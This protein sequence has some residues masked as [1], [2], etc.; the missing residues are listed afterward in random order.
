[1]DSPT[2]NHYPA[3]RFNL[4]LSGS[5]HNASFNDENDLH[6][7][8]F[9]S[10]IDHSFQ[11]ERR[12]SLE[13]QT[14]QLSNSL[15]STNQSLNE[16][17]NRNQAKP[18][19]IFKQ[20][21]RRLSPA[22][23]HLTDANNNNNSSN[24]N[25]NIIRDKQSRH[26]IGA[27]NQLVMPPSNNLRTNSLSLDLNGNAL[28][29]RKSISNQYSPDNAFDSWQKN[30]N[31][32]QYDSVFESPQSSASDQIFNDQNSKLESSFISL[33]ISWN[34]SNAEDTSLNHR[35]RKP[36]NSTFVSNCVS[37]NISNGVSNPA[38]TSN[39]SS[40]TTS[41]TESLSCLES[42]F[43]CLASDLNEFLK[44]LGLD[45]LKSLFEEKNVDLH[46]FLTLSEVDLKQFGIT[47]LE[48]LATL[49][50]GQLKFKEI[51]SIGSSESMSYVIYLGTQLER[52]KKELAKV[53]EENRLYKMGLTDIKGFNEVKENKMQ[54]GY[55]R[56]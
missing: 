45:E 52:T 14:S 16:I 35:E 50:A 15:L 11:N 27:A 56:F 1:M 28:T 47:N 7:S 17:L 30:Q 55:S 6:Q 53:K 25:S 29:N 19:P 42:K 36:R 43:A 13:T 26:S 44:Q 23:H 38:S 22:S 8:S 5:N 49:I 33:N 10:S 32:F 41:P 4:I 51:I 31:L 3:D 46:T 9:N 54:N 12:F 40:Q 2:S 20:R 37:N 39:S 21:Q 48:H 24:N 18:R 34:D